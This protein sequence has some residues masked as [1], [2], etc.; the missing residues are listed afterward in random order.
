MPQA[1]Q[2]GDGKRALGPEFWLLPPR[3]SSTNPATMSNVA[4]PLPTRAQP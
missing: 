4:K 2:H 3:P 1:S